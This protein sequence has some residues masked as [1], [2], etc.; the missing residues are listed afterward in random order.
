MG[1]SKTPA[2]EAW[3][4]LGRLSVATLKHNPTC[5]VVD[6]GS[7]P[8]VP[9]VAPAKHVTS[10]NQAPLENSPT[11]AYSFVVFFFIHPA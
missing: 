1:L 11:G 10:F 7:A 4:V 8:R 9:V 3:G 6:H 5:K 2:A